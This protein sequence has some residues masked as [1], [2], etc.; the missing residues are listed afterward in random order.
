MAYQINKTD[1]TVIASVADGQI[2]TLSTDLTLIGKN[3]SGFGES[4]NENFVKLLEN[5]ASTARPTRPIRGQI[6][7]DVSELKLKV[8]SGTQFLPVSSATISNTQ[9][10]TLGVGDLW[11]NNIDKQLYFFDGT[12]PILLGPSYS[13]SQG[14][15]GLKVLS[16]LDTEN[17]T[18]V[19]TQL[20]NNGILLGI[21]SKD[22]FTPKTAID[23]FTGS[24]T[25]GFNS[26]GADPLST[27]KFNVTV[28]NSEQL[29]RSPATNYVRKDSFSETLAG[30]LDI[31]N[32]NGLQ[33]GSSN[34]CE[35]RVISSNVF[36]SNTSEN[37]NLILRVRTNATPE[38]AIVIEAATRTVDIYKDLPTS[39]VN[40]G[41]SLTVTGNLTVNGT[42]TTVNTQTLEVED[43][44]IDLA[45]SAAPSDELADGG[46]ITIKGTNYTASFTGSISGDTLTVGSVSVGSIRLFMKIAGTGI[47]TDTY[48]VSFVSTTGGDP[49]TDSGSVWKVSKNNSVSGI[50]IT[51]QLDGHKLLWTNASQAWNS[52]EHVNLMS[53]KEFKINGLTVLS[54][55]SLGNGITAIPGVSSFG[56]QTIIRVGPGLATDLASTAIQ[57][58]NNR[59]ST[60]QT[61]Q[62][63]EIEPQGTGNIA[64]IGNP[65][66]TGLANPISGPSG[67]FDAATREYVDNRLETRPIVFTVDL[68]D[69]KTNS[70]IITN[71]LNN[72]APTNELRDGTFARILCNILSNSSTVLDL[73]PLITAGTSTSNFLTNLSGSSSPAVTSISVT[74]AT[75]SA[76]SISTTRIIKEFQVILGNWSFVRDIS[77]P[78]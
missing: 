51:G 19:I 58:E 30:S 49:G 17:Q 14:L 16:L 28:T 22:T 48:I 77:L 35:I 18:R 8:Y 13:V 3:Y 41:G 76:S 12:T 45:S 38:E 54:G 21:F 29:G 4:L 78:L 7:F 31:K 70:Y 39:Q 37:K 75:I 69:G 34:Q 10:T 23:G 60:V 24:I 40:I 44:N 66:I 15:S 47:D 62:N 68:T 55:N 33:I 25:P 32:D 6:W 59:I 73:N 11:F 50:S 74:P 26:A 20:Y 65:R 43:K 52:T 9:P 67:Q 71:I 46:G 63:L 1:G 42:S 36:I 57:I 53:G 72:L 2:D 64:L 56:K 27:F 5:F 61:N